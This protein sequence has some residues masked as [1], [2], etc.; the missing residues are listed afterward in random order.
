[1]LKAWVKKNHILNTVSRKGECEAKTTGEAI[2][3]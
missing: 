2:R 3:H 1:M